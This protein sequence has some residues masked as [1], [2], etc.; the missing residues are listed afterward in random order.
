MSRV[1]GMRWG[2]LLFRK[3]ATSQAYAW[4]P[5]QRASDDR[6]RGAGF[7]SSDT[8]PSLAAS[9][10]GSLLITA[11]PAPA[12]ADGRTPGSFAVSSTGEAQ[13]SIPIFAPP[14]VN[15]LA[16]QLALTY[17]HR[18]E[19]TL[20][21][22]G[23]GVS[24]L[25][26]I[27]RC[28]KTWAQNN[29]A[30]APQNAFDDRYCLDEMQLRHYSGNYGEP[31]STYR[32]E[33]ETYARIT[34]LGPAAGDGPGAFRVEHKN[35]L[36]YEYGTSPDS[37]ILSI[38]QPEAR[39]WAVNRI[40]DRSGN[41]IT[42]TWHDDTVNGSY[43]IDRIDY[44]GTTIDF[45]WEAKPVGEIRSAYV[46]GS[47]VREIHR[48]QAIDVRQGA[49]VLRRFDLAYEGP[50]STTSRSRLASVQECAGSVCRDATTFDY[51]DGSAAASG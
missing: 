46:T 51:Q 21:G 44:A 3:I 16:P 1:A 36:I 41:E 8:G 23:W 2:A 7:T 26:S 15:G 6:R 19:G 38:G 17:S 25:S 9:V 30:K 32:T 13:Y 39:A 5:V 50:L 11:A 40:S 42:F 47:Q 31:G 49:T 4:T 48:L 33:I 12:L 43:R 18:H 37:Q 10:V 20:A 29:E 14:G 34:A 27:H 35:G 22:V 28:E 24:G 45:Q